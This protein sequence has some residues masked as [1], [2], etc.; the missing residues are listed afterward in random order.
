[1]KAVLMLLPQNVAKSDKARQRLGIDCDN[2]GSVQKWPSLNS[3]FPPSGYL[4]WNALEVGDGD[5][6][7]YYWP[8]GREDHEPLVCTTE[9]DI[10][11][12]VPLAS[13]LAGCLRLLKAARPEIAAEIKEIAQDCGISLA[14]A[15]SSAVATP[16]HVLSTLD[17]R[18]P[19]PLL[20]QAR[21]PMR[22]ADLT[23]CERSLLDALEILPEY[24]LA[25]VV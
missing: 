24:G 8:G 14:R 1:M 19:E 12:V 25:I 10:C 18:S 9:H 5:T 20:A 23:L 6:Y 4:P 15:Q 17:L 16:D 21:E 11:R 13:D 22:T 7:G 3:C 2:E